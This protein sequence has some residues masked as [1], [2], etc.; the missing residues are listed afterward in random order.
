MAIQTEITFHEVE[1]SDALEASIERW[2]SRL[3]HLHDRIVHCH[4]T[5]GQPHR[6]HRRGRL[7]DVHVK[8]DISGSE[9]VTAWESEDVYLAVAD[10][11]RAAR[12]QLLDELGVRRGKAKAPFVTRYITG[13]S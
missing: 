13:V 5:V 9:I 8:L 10:A 7:F 1:H 12:R 6:H 3:E 4:V 2:V 11:F